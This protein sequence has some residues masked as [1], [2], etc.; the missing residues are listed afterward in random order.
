MKIAVEGCAHGD[1]EKIYDT[2]EYIENTENYKVDLLIC[3]GDFQST[4]NLDDLECMAVPKKF[5][6]IC[7]FYK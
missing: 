4:R 6:D 7:S 2:I 1:L 3:C 5:Q